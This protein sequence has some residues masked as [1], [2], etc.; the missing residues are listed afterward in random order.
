MSKS[1]N[2]NQF[3]AAINVPV[4]NVEFVEKEWHDVLRVTFAN[5][6][7]ASILKEMYLPKDTEPRYELAVIDYRGNLNYCNPLTDDVMRYQTYEEILHSMRIMSTWPDTFDDDTDFEKL[8]TL[9]Q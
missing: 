6:W 2:L 9:P 1:D 3:V 8:L 5:G 4:T 7:T